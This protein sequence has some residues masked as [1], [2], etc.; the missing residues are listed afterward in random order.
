MPKRGSTK[1]RGYSGAHKIQRRKWARIVAAGGVHCARCGGAIFPDEKFD[2]DHD[3]ADRSRYLG[4]SHVG[5]NRSAPRRRAARLR[6]RRQ[7][8]RVW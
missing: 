1:L 7:H 8:S 5:C 4:A 3:D 2:L 6:R